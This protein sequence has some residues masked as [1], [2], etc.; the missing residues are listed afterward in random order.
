M[1]AVHGA[2][3]IA[4]DS[5]VTIARDIDSRLDELVEKELIRKVQEDWDVAEAF[6][7]ES[8]PATLTPLIERQLDALPPDLRELLEVASVSG[9]E[10]T[11]AEL[12]A[13]S[14]HCTAW[15]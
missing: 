3:R 14:G 4:D 9:M 13:A 11:A 10:F 1:N 15:K 2:L 7:L 6:R 5:C 12:A 8:V